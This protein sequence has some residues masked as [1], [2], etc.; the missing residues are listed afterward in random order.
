MSARV[1]LEHPV[2]VEGAAYGELSMRRPKVRDMRD[3]EKGGGGKA[4]TEIRLFANLCEV[5]P[6][7][8][9]EMDLADYERLQEAFGAMLP[10]RPAPP[11]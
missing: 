2:T 8:I 9:E 7:V 10:K 6:A 4:E 1:E 5:A 3:A 11:T